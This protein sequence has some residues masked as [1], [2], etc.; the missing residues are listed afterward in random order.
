MSLNSSHPSILLYFSIRPGCNMLDFSI[1]LDQDHVDGRS[2]VFPLRATLLRQLRTLWDPYIRPLTLSEHNNTHPK[3]PFGAKVSQS[4]AI[5]SH[6]PHWNRR[7][8]VL[9]RHPI[10]TPSLPTIIANPKRS[11]RRKHALCMYSSPLYCKWNTECGMIQSPTR[12]DKTHHPSLHFPMSTFV[13][14]PYWRSYRKE[15]KY[16]SVLT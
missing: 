5:T 6:L 8:V 9:S 11:Y 7:F 16:L 14:A 10:T 4:F 13:L 15:K 2:I 1:P 3:T 12:P